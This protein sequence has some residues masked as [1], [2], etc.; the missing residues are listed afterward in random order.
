M[1][2]KVFVSAGKT[3]TPEQEAFVSA[4]EDTLRTLGAEPHTVDRNDFTSE[5]PLARIKALMNESAGVLVLAYE[6]T[7]V[8]EGVQKG[9]T[10]QERTLR[11]ALLTS[12]WNQI[13]AGMAFALAKPVLVVKQR[14]VLEEG[15]MEKIGDWY[16][17]DTDISGA[18]VTD[19]R[20][21][22]VVRHWVE[23]LARVAASPSKVI[24]GERLSLSDLLLRI[25]VGQLWGVAAIV[26]AVLAATASGSYYLG[27][28]K[29]LGDPTK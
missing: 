25:P 12:V 2:I 7:R 10:P 15:L 23:N 27:V 13:E 16:M 3:W 14:D 21:I 22:G 9:G 28:L 26:F 18:A 20:F 6:R 8:R 5:K 17:L 24:D 29:V 4:V 11:D 19:K 1:A